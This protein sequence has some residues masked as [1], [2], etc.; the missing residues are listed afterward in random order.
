MVS[1]KIKIREF[2]IVEITIPLFCV[3]L[4]ISKEVEKPKDIVNPMSYSITPERHGIM[5]I[6]SE[7]IF[8]LNIV[9]L[10]C[11]ASTSL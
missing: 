7:N 1:F 5:K 9:Y 2:F 8:Q 11:R 3:I 10:C 6:M 4:R